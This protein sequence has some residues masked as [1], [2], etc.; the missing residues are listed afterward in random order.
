MSPGYAKLSGQKSSSTYSTIVDVLA[1]LV[2]TTT[3]TDQHRQ[4][5]NGFHSRRTDQGRQR[6]QIR[7]YC[8]GRNFFMYISQCPGSKPLRLSQMLHALWLLRR[9]IPPAQHCPMQQIRAT[10]NTLRQAR[11]PSCNPYQRQIYEIEEYDAQCTAACSSGSKDP[12]PYT[13][14]YVGFYTKELLEDSEGQCYMKPL[15][16][17]SKIYSCIPQ[18]GTGAFQPLTAPTET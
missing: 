10:D 16:R 14:L 8:R 9:Q 4:T 15:P 18:K 11:V 1:F 2:A 6:H 5:H 12:S 13:D 17:S 3:Q 7:C